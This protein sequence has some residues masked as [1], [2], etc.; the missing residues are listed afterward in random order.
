[1]WSE[2]LPWDSLLSSLLLT[3]HDAYGDIWE[4]LFSGF[5]PLA[6]SRA[7][8]IRY[9]LETHEHGVQ[10]EQSNTAPTIQAWALS[11]TASALGL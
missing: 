7:V 2:L 5:W 9:L 1:M 3:C 10:A 8:Q 6:F 11:L 4:F